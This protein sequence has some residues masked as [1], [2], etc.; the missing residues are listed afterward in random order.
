VRVAGDDGEV[1]GP[2][3]E[4]PVERGRVVRMRLGYPERVLAGR[5]DVGGEAFAGQAA[6]D[7][8]RHPQVVLD[9]QHAHAGILHPK[10]EPN[11]TAT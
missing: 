5:G 8:A 2:H 11:M 4:L 9:D 6:P 7:E 3:A 10:D 1:L